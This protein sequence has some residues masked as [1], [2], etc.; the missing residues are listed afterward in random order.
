[1]K[2]EKNSTR[3]TYKTSNN[4]LLI[5]NIIVKFSK[6][7]VHCGGVVHKNHSIAFRKTECEASY[8]SGT[9]REVELAVDQAY[10]K[11]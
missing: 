9:R 10:E 5:T 3:T 4:A 7:D 8:D 6:M 1:M 11:L 2:D